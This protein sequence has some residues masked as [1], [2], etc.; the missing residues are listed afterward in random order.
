MWRYE[1]HPA[2]MRPDYTLD[3]HWERYTPQEHAMWRTLFERQSRMLPGRAC[4]EFLDGLENLGITLDG[5]P[6]FDQISDILEKR[7][8]WRLVTVP[9]L[10]PDDIFFQHLTKRQFPV[11]Y[12]IRTPEKMDY[13]QEP[14]VFHDLFGHVPLLI[15]PVFADYMH[16]FGEGG[17]KA[18][19]M[20]AL[21]N[22]GRLY[23]FTV[24]FGLIK[25]AEGLR[26]Y[27]SGIVSSKTESIYCLES[28]APN[29]LGFDL[30]RIMRTDYRIDNVQESY[31]VI[32]G[33]EQLFEA[34]RPDFAPYYQQ[35]K[36]LPDYEKGEIVPGDQVLHQGSV[37]FR[38]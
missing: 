25:T 37:G 20:G 21:K 5:I 19:S 24:E 29:R 9:G 18:L 13:L 10:I 8:G 4:N 36:T 32:D 38:R 23:W 6:R 15:N 3:Q 31:F 33:F 12:W 34:T 14:D 26:I 1:E 7:T 35:L 22:I 16:A 11:T 27:G 2:D 17:I 28:D 30:M